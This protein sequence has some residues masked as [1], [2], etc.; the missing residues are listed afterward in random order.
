MDFEKNL[1]EYMAK[2][3]NEKSD[4][5]RSYDYCKRSFDIYYKKIVENNEPLTDEI[6]EDFSRS[7][8]CF[9]A[10]WGMVCRRSFLLSHSYKVLFGACEVL[11]SGDYKDIL[12]MDPLKEN[13]D[14]KRVWQLYGALQKKL[15]GA[16]RLL[17][18][19]ILMVTYG[20]VIAYDSHECASLEE[21]GIHTNWNSTL[22]EALLKKTEEII[23]GN[24]NRFE[25][26]INDAV[27]AHME[28]KLKKEGAEYE[29]V[30][31][32]SLKV[33]DMCLWAAG[34]E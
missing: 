23:L 22:D 12:G 10:S 28:E 21:F 30:K 18:C 1:A 8:Y 25:N 4:R 2:W 9:L 15:K 6:K 5:M 27:Y 24:K 17:L 33:L 14:T 16:S 29:A 13:Y 11:F 32:T 31:Y 19:K 7:L 34:K 20:C 26:M 3:D